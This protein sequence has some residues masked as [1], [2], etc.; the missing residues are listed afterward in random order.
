MV[1]TEVKNQLQ[2][3]RN[4][5]GFT[6]RKITDTPTDNLAVVNR[7]YVNLNGAT[8]SRPTSSVVGQYYFDTTLGKPIWWSGTAFVDATGSVV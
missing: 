3:Y 1:R 6:D 2:S 8:G 4:D 7:R 5:W